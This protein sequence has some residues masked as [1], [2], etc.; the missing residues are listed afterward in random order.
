M[1]PIETFATGIAAAVAKGVLRLWLKDDPVALSA[2]TTT[3]DLLKS[4]LTDFIDQ[5]SAGREL[6]KIT[7]RSARSFAT[8]MEQDETSLD[9]K[10]VAFIAN[11]AG[12]VID[13]TDLTAE[14]LA[15]NDLDP[16]QLTAFF[17]SRTG[18]QGGNPDL[19][20]S[21]DAE[22]RQLFERLLRSASQQVIDISSR[23]PLFTERAFREMLQR[24][25]R[26]FRVAERVL[27]GVDQ[28]LARQRGDDPEADRY[29]TQFRLACIR[30]YDRLQL[31]GVDLDQSNQRYKLDVAYV[32]LQVEKTTL[33]G[34][35]DNLEEASDAD[36]E[37]DFREAMPV[38]Q[39]LA[40]AK[41]LLV[42]GLAGAGKTT[43]VQWIAVYCAA[44]DHVGDLES[45]NDLIPFV[46]K[47]RDLE[48][49]QLPNPDA[50]ATVVAPH[51]GGEPTG[52]SHRTLEQ[53]RAIVLI[54]GL[55]EAAEEQREEVAG[56]L[57]NLLSQ[58]PDVRYVVTTRPYA[59]DEGWLEDDDFVDATL[60]DMPP[61]DVSR[62]VDHW[63]EAVASGLDKDEEKAE[64]PELARSLKDELRLNA[65]LAKL[66]ASPLLSAMICALHR[67]RNQALPKN[68]LGLYRACIDMF[69]RRD[70]ERRVRMEDYAQIA[71]DDKLL[72]LRSLAW[73]LIRNGLSSAT[74]AETTERL[75]RALSELNPPPQDVTGA[76]AMRLFVHRVAMLQ[77][78]ATGKV[79]FP[80]RTFQEYLAA[81]EAVAE[82]DY[83]LL[84]DNAHREQWREVV[85][86]AAG[87]IENKTAAEDF[88]MKLLRRGD[89][90]PKR[91][92]AL[93]LIGAAAHQNVSRLPDEVRLGTEVR[94]RLSSI[95]PPA[96]LSSASSLASVGNLVVPLLTYDSSR[97]APVLA[98]CVR[99]L[100]MINSHEAVE[101]L[102]GYLDDVRVT[103]W[104]AIGISVSYLSDDIRESFVEE[105]EKR[106]LAVR[107]QHSGWFEKRS[108]PSTD[109]IETVHL[110]ALQ[111]V[112]V[113][114]VL[115]TSVEFVTL[116]GCRRLRDLEAL[117]DCP[118]LIK[119]DIVD[120]PS[121]T[122]LR[123]LAKCPKLT[124]VRISRCSIKLKIGDLVECQ[125]LRMV[126]LDR[127]IGHSGVG[128]ML[129]AAL[130]RLRVVWA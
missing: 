122:S 59:V 35:T 38:D 85:I 117:R 3:A 7:E 54:D 62:F 107:L 17:M 72:L 81:Q 69:F 48:N 12:A 37:S 87:V 127:R 109:S 78:F 80:H 45:C 33:D 103:V 53:G 66:A 42:R 30:K 113:L 70:N 106:E 77:Q 94:D 99:T 97:K 9:D 88:V 114:P 27:D 92:E 63:H 29:E 82:G 96:K 19:A 8:M 121:I 50:F 46:I 93:Y 125:S 84:I 32:T 105:A 1:L 79:N 31:F 36:D 5:R 60:Q 120:C 39:A 55:D 68:R 11:A 91:R 89:K 61:S 14:L 100:A 73:W 130:P 76:K 13:R 98:A 2:S 40:K 112:R 110:D 118:E 126:V 101:V 51:T 102:E 15:Q 16:D 47:L 26:L 104:R 21:D 4:K 41:R 34:D 124:V 71:D 49:G 75:D 65:D 44:K 22:R 116:I 123:A 67:D 23:L 111:M 28:L 58:Y 129:R 90:E 128:R 10:S 108:L 20:Q 25:N 119:L 64:L 86:L 6:D 24:E 95:I 56:W 115:P 74:V 83:K 57:K 52:W 18:A 43:L